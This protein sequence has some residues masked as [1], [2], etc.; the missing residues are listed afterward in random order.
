MADWLDKFAE[1]I[2]GTFCLLC[3]ARLEESDTCCPGC[4]GI[5]INKAFLNDLISEGKQL[6]V[7][8]GLEEGDE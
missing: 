1:S 2:E 3:Y 8:L 5:E 4:G 7:A 6:A